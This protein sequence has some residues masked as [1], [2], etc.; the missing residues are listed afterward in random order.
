MAMSDHDKAKEIAR[1]QASP[2]RTLTAAQRRQWQ[3]FQTRA[4]SNRRGH[5]QIGEGAKMVAV[6]VE[7]GLL[8]EMDAYVKARGIKRSQLV[9]EGVRMVMRAKSG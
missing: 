1:A 8:K 2:P 4:K 3:Q 5:P 6:S 7:K 9:A